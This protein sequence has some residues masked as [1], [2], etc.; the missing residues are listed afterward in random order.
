MFDEHKYAGKKGKK[1][2]SDKT[3]QYVKK[4]NKMSKNVCQKKKKKN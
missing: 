2:V 3:I 1:M 4:K